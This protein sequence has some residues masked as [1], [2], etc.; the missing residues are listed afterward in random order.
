MTLQELQH[1]AT[2]NGFK[3]FTADKSCEK[4]VSSYGA[5]ECI[6]SGKVDSTDVSLSYSRDDIGHSLLILHLK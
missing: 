3:D 4:E 6:L 2:A 5:Y 1:L